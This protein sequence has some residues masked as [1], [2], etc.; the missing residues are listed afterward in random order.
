METSCKEIF[1]QQLNNCISGVVHSFAR[2]EPGNEYQ[3][4]IEDKF[5]N[6][7]ILEVI[8][9]NNGEFDIQ[10]EDLPVN[11]MNP[12]AGSFLITAKKPQQCDN[13]VFTICDNEYSAIKISTNQHDGDDYLG[14]ICP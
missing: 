14:C 11:L 3:L 2:L 10:I 7:F 8:T 1:E 9:D 13:S 12:Y 6:Q 5:K 4:I